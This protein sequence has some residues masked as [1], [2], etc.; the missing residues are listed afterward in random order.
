[1]WSSRRCGDGGNPLRAAWTMRPGLAIVSIL[2]SVVFLTKYSPLISYTQTGMAH[3]KV[4]SSI[5]SRPF[6]SG[7]QIA[8]LDPGRVQLVR[9]KLDSSPLANSPVRNVSHIHTCSSPSH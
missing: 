4:L 5:I 3:I 7:R 8:C 2:I 1:V 6:W 9:P